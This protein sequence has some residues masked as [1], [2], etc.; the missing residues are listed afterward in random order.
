M[1][2]SEI[3]NQVISKILSTL[4]KV[5]KAQISC[6]IEVYEADR[7]ER[8]ELVK[9]QPKN[10]SDIFTSHFDR[11]RFEILWDDGAFT[12]DPQAIGKVTF[13]NKIDSINIY[14]YIKPVEHGF[15][16]CVYFKIII[17]GF[18]LSEFKQICEILNDDIDEETYIPF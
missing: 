17:D 6:F 14:L 1:S 2:D 3:Y 5:S 8:Y 15:P 11:T 18:E 4:R 9:I 12:I 7:G 10:V 16:S 13:K